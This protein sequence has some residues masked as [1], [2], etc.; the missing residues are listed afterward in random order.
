M[1]S[2]A[3]LKSLWKQGPPDIKNKSLPKAIIMQGKHD[4]QTTSTATT[5]IENQGTNS[6]ST[7]NIQKQI[8][9]ME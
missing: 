2:R 7:K 9:R 1:N 4:N 5:T 3:Y 8:R 6:R